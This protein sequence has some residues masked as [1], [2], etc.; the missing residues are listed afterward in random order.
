MSAPGTLPTDAFARFWSDMAARIAA[1]GVA[2]PQPPPDVLEQVRRQFFEAMSTQADQFLRSEV[3][4]NSL[5]QGMDASLAWQKALNEFLRKG[6]AGAQ[7]PSRADADHLVVLLRGMEERL[8]ERLDDV[9]RR[10]E[11]LEQGA[12]GGTRQAE[13]TWKAPARTRA[14]AKRRVAKA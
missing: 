10:V 3:F 7:L 8:L 4:L 9:T 1:A 12:R 13:R 11:R 2:P 5:K 14:A 6:L